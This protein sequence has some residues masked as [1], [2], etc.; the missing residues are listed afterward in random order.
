MA[1]K[2]ECPACRSYSSRIRRAFDDGESCPCCD[3]SSATATEILKARARGADAE[4]TAKYT[5]TAHELDQLR[6]EACTLREKL[7]QI[8]MILDLPEA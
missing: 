5:A 4:L 8:R 3:L 2:L 1:D 6:S 7:A